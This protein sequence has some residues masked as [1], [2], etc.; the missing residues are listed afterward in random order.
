MAEKISAKEKQVVINQPECSKKI[1][2][3]TLVFS[4][5]CTSYVSEQYQ[6]YKQ[7]NILSTGECDETTSIFDTLSTYG[8]VI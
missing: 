4:S 6:P 7:T 5:W 1:V 2:A 3:C 8:V